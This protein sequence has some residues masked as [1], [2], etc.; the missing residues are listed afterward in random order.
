MTLVG[1]LPWGSGGHGKSKNLL[2]SDKGRDGSMKRLSS[3]SIAQ[4]TLRLA[5]QDGQPAPLQGAYCGNDDRR[6]D[7]EASSS[8]ARR[9]KA[10]PRST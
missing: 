2:S 9:I 6:A 8:L 5:C 10:L 4:Q 1:P 7:D 3:V